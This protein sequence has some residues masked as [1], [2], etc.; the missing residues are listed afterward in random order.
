MGAKKTKIILSNPKAKIAVDLFGGAITG[1]HLQNGKINPLSFCFSKNHMPV[2]NRKGATYKGHFI[3]LGRWGEPSPGEKK[4]GIPYHGGFAG[5]LWKLHKKNNTGIT[6]LAENKL[7]GLK[8]NRTIAIDTNQAVFHTT[9]TITNTQALGRLY[10][11]VQHPTIAVPFLSDN[12]KVFCNAGRGFHYE[13][14]KEPE[15]FSANWPKGKLGGHSTLNLTKSKGGFTSVFSFVLKKND[16]F[17]WIA[18]YSP[19]HNLLLGYL[20]NANDYPWIN[21]WQDYHQGKI[22]YRGLEFGTSGIHQPFHIM[23]QNNKIKIFDTP[24]FEF[25]DAGQTT[26]K[27]YLCFLVKPDFKI[28]SVK[29]ISMNDADVIIKFSNAKRE[30]VIPT[31]LKRVFVNI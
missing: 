7:E 25:I 4:Q 19:Q 6:M 10:N 26:K 2:D 15:K 22:R 14:F 1:F 17:G 27:E 11:I 9:E 3:C 28:S 30:L 21:M 8:I 23:L 29:S 20:W 12:T 18:A 13:N 5:K 24:V 16:K 31:L